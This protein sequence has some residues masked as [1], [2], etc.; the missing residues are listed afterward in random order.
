MRRLT[1]LVVALLASLTLPG[2]ALGDP[3]DLLGTVTL[4]G[5]GA[6]SVAGT[7]DGTHY[8]TIGSDTC[9]SATLQV[10]V[11]P[12]GGNGAATLVSSKSI[13]DGAGNA[14]TISALAW[15]PSRNMVWGAYDNE[16][17]LIDVG[18]PTVSGDALATF[19]FN[20]GVGGIPLIDGLAYDGS[21]DTLYHSPDVDCNAYHFSLGT[22][23]NPLGTLLNTVTPKNAAGASDCL[24]SGVA[25]GSGDTLYI[26]RDGD[27]EIRRVD[28]TT[29]DF[30]SQ[31]ATTVGRVE[32]LTCD[33][34]TYAPKEA[35]LAK[36]ARGSLYEAFEV[37]AGT[38]PLQGEADLAITKSDAPDPVALGSDLTYTVTV[39]NNGPDASTGSTVTDTL[40]A[41]VTFVSATPSQGSCSG[42]VTCDLGLL[43]SGA[44]ATVAIVVTVDPAATCPLANTATVSGVEPDP[45]SANNS[46]TVETDCVPAPAECAGEV[47]TIVG[48]AGDDAIVGTP[49]PDVIQ[50][51][52]GDDSVLALGGNDLICGD[53]GDD[54]IFGGSGR[55]R[56]IGDNDDDSLFGG[57]DRDELDG[58]DGADE[59]I[60]G[61]GDDS[62]AGGSG[63]DELVGGSDD[64]ELSG[65]SGA[66]DLFGG[67]GDD[68]AFG[69]PGTDDLNGGAGDDQLSGENGDDD[70]SGNRGDDV[71]FGGFGDDE[72]FGSSG[73]DQLL[74]ETGDDELAGGT[75]NDSLDGGADID[76]C[77]GGFGTDADAG[78]EVVISIP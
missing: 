75:G 60:G 53:D 43:A 2:T 8:L 16:V 45:D 61:R 48:T 18:D 63:R 68:M 73:D 67:A 24:V 17:W 38:C 29:G 54:E 55:D 22:D 46:A 76:D 35:I 71:L 7:F 26:G 11:A 32:A 33:P 13:V 66:D 52:D 70:V 65:N 42:T 41:G 51:L 3:G 30:V 58:S 12:L 9:A 20:P 4:P 72:L 50:L 37:E 39:T 49:G 5:N 59:L 34:V 1:S 21:D 40:P 27:A 14:V 69:G 64:D 62:L 36:D 15:D 57:R 44:S 28:K 19:Q 23:G 56:L 78:C 6:C 10:Y 31:F 74:G 25:V 47:A 77:D